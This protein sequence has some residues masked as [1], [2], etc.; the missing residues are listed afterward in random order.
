LVKDPFRSKKKKK[1]SKL[2]A[3]RFEL[4]KGKNLLEGNLFIKIMC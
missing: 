4:A 2:H 1:I 3:G